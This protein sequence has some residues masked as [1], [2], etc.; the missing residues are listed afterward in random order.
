MRVLAIEWARF[1]NLCNSIAAGQFV[2]GTLLTKYPQ[3]MVDAEGQPL[4]EPRRP[5][6]GTDE[7]V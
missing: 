6:P 7:A 2:T 3:P 4:A 1:G 5:T